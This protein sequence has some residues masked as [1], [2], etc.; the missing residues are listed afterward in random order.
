MKIEKSKRHSLCWLAGFLLCVSTVFAQ[1]DD[2]EDA[3]TQRSVG[4]AS[5]GTLEGIVV[6]VKPGETPD[7]KNVN[8][9][10]L[11]SKMT[12]VF[13]DHYDLEKKQIVLDLYDT[14]LGESPIDSVIQFP[15]KGSTVEQTEIDLNKDVEGLRPDLRDVVRITL[16]SDYNVPYQVE[17]EFGVINL[18]FKWSRKIEKQLAADS[19]AL[20]WQ[21]PLYT[22]LAGGAG[23]G[24]WWWLKPTDDPTPCLLCDNIGTEPPSHPGAQ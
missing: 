1:F 20:Y 17:E 16:S 14:K 6:E 18:R 24:L 13:F 5:S 22:V 7:A 2:F 9:V 11:L 15:I 8:V 12:S 4:R 3:P 21:V 10:F 23:F 19:R